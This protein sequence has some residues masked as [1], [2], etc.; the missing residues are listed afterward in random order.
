[1]HATWK[2]VVL[3]AGLAVMVPPVL[4]QAPAKKAVARY[5]EPQ[6]RV[7]TAL[8]T[9]MKDEVMQGAF[10]V[11]Q[12]QPEFRMDLSSKPPICITSNPDAKYVPVAPNWSPSADP[13]GNKPKPPGA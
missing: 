9:C 11:K 10:C 8:D 4:A 6:K 2:A 3:L 7:R 12:C 13:A 1:M 5:Y